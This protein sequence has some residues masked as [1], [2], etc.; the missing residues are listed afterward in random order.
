[1]KKISF[2]H[3]IST[4]EASNW[5]DFSLFVNQYSVFNHFVLRGQ[6]DST[7]L[8]EPTLDRSFKDTKTPIGTRERLTVSHLEKFKYATRGRRGLNPSEIKTEND[9]WALGQHYGLNTPLL[10]WTNSPFVAAYFSM[11]TKQNSAS[12]FRVVFG[13]SQLSVKDMS[14]EISKKTI[15][16]ERPPIIDF[17]NPLTDENNRLVNQMGLF[18]RTPIG[19]D[20]ESWYKQNFPEKGEFVRMW[21]I[22]I[23]E[24]ERTKALRSLN[25][26]NINHSTLFP[27]LYGASKFVNTNLEIDKY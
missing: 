7:W 25:R 12:G 19:I 27:D 6:A 22:L 26:M 20:I 21:K 10:D 9:W 5:N 23:P 3:G 24:K 15:K 2:E 11:I 17:V 16:K 18:T 8:L 13:I 14:N 4:R 1:M